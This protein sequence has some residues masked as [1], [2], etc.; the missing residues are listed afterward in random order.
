MPSLVFS[1]FAAQRGLRPPFFQQADRPPGPDHVRLQI[2]ASAPPARMN[3]KN[4]NARVLETRAKDRFS[5][6]NSWMSLHTPKDCGNTTK[7][8]QSPLPYPAYA[9]DILRWR[10]RV[11]QEILKKAK[12]RPVLKR[13]LA[14][15]FEL[16][17]EKQG[18]FAWPSLVTLA[19]RLGYRGKNAKATA[20]KYRDELSRLGFVEIRRRT[21]RDGRDTS[22]LQRIKF[23]ALIR[24]FAKNLKAFIENHPELRPGWSPQVSKVETIN[25][26]SDAKPS[27]RFNLLQ[28]MAKQSEAIK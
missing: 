7:N 2:S 11:R 24:T 14:V 8:T 27:V 26:N 9:H 17:N 18:G 25:C 22:N 12:N 21:L 3:S 16:S 10:W 5:R 19:A 1:V 23:S 28:Q 6:R 15:L 20:K 13:V 4:D